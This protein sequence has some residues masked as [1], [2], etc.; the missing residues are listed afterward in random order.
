MAVNGYLGI[1]RTKKAP[2]KRDVCS[3]HTL[4]PR[5]QHDVCSCPNTQGTCVLHDVWPCRNTHFKTLKMAIA[6]LMQHHQHM[7][8][9]ILQPKKKF[10]GTG[11][12]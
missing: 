5:E 9:K 8:C 10:G 2:I 11:T 4:L 12:K 3:V 1:E 6:K 7:Y